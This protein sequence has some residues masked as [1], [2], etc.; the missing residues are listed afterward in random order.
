MKILELFAGAGGF[1]LGLEEAD[2][3][4][5][6]TKWANQWEPGQRT[7]TAFGVYDYHYPDSENINEDIA[8]VSNERLQ[9]MD[10]DII[11][12]G[13]PCQDYSVARGNQGSLGIEGKKG[14]LFWEVVRA[15]EQ[16]KPSYLILE[17][18]DRLLTSPSAQRGRDFG[19]ILSAFNNL[20]YTV[21]WRV[22]NAA[23]Y[24]RAQRRRRTFMF[25]SKNDTLIAKTSS[26]SHDHLLTRG[27]FARQFPVEAYPNKDR[28]SVGKLSNDIVAISESFHENFWKS[29]I[30]Q[31]GHY[32]SIDTIPIEETPITLGEIV[33]DSVDEKYYLTDMKKLE[34][35]QS[36]R[37][38]KAVE[39]TAPDG[40]KY[41]YREGR[42]SPYDSLDLP[43]RTLLTTEGAIS[44]TTHLIKDGDR[45]RVLTPLE[46]E[47]L[48][49]FPDD[50]TRYRKDPTGTIKEVSDSQRKFLTGNALVVGV[51]KRIGIEFKKIL[52]DLS[53]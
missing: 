29:G 39:R 52:G 44:R 4:L 3:D 48:Q 15:T 13:F 7:Q 40:H 27:I 9:E 30:M 1:R 35:F 38:G 8:T 6:Q 43:G 32:L 34:K 19:I 36:K 20:G 24:G 42:M 28:V 14:V 33:L 53:K 49:D 26:V 23:E 37:G 2:S 21:E 5:F 25:V 47:R 31:N 11:V 41:I 51:V 45:F 46:T 16:I 12:G 22:I 17:N 10:A 50:W 18:V